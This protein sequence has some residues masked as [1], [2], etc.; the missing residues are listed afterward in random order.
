MNENDTK[1]LVRLLELCTPGDLPQDVFIAIARLCVLPGIEFVPLRKNEG[2]IEVLLTQRGD[3]D[4]YWPSMFHTP[5]TILRPTDASFE[6][7]FSRLFHDE[8]GISYTPQITFVGYSFGRGLRG[9]GVGFEYI[10]H[11]EES[12]NGTFCPIDQLPSNFIKEQQALL[13]RCV[14]K[15]QSV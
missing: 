10:V 8:L 12:T 5:G 9:S 15:F 6:D 7:A 1:E 14:D 11:L 3:D 2:V 13:N 4:S